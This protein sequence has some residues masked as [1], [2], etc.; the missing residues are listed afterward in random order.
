MDE[1]ACVSNI[2]KKY[3]QI[4]IV[5]VVYYREPPVIV[6]MYFATWYCN[7]LQVHSTFRDSPCGKWYYAHDFGYYLQHILLLARP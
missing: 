2:R 3:S 1:H 7:G 6:V 5:A 4:I